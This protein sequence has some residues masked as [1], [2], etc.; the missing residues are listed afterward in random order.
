ML[1]GS[2]QSD[3][4]NFVC[5]D[6]KF[7]IFSV[8]KCL[9]IGFAISCALFEKFSSILE[10]YLKRRVASNNI[11]HSLY[12]FLIAGSQRTNEC[13]VIIKYFVDAYRK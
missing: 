2:F 11:V 13:E 9:S 10:W 6:K 3:L 7:I 12:D 5:L 8:N 1:L 4:Q